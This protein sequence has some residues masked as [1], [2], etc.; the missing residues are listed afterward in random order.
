MREIKFR[1]WIPEEHR[2]IYSEPGNLGRFFFVVEQLKKAGSKVKVQ[3]FTGLKDRNGKEIYEGDIVRDVSESDLVFP[4]AFD[5]EWAGYRMP[6]EFNEEYAFPLTE[7]E[8]EVIGNIY[9]NPELLK[10]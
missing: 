9:E 5:V 4:V 8:L 3:Q 2:F 7:V 6:K 10:A 1:E